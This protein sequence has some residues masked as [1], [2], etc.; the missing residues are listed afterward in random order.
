MKK[1]LYCLSYW[2]WFYHFSPVA[3][4]KKKQMSL[5]AHLTRIQSLSGLLPTGK[6]WIQLVLMK[7]LGISIS[8]QHMR[9]YT[10]WK[11]QNLHQ[12]Q[13]LQKNIR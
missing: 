2:Y 8:M 12:S 1:F 13:P 11:G 6:P 9:I 10:R 3:M 4:M 5:E 7:C